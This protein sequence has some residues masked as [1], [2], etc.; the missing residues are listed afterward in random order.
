MEPVLA[1]CW[2]WCWCKGFGGC[3][4]EFG[5]TACGAPLPVQT[6][7]KWLIFQCKKTEFDIAASLAEVSEQVVL[8]LGCQRPLDTR[9]I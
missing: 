7:I 5:A 1:D 9:D 4:E 3:F 6:P 8:P 2:C